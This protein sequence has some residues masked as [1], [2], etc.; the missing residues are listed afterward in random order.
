MPAVHHSDP[1]HGGG[2]VRQSD[3]TDKAPVKDRF[4]ATL[5]RICWDIPFR[6]RSLP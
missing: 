5:A 2:I 4:D 3:I 1:V 6:N